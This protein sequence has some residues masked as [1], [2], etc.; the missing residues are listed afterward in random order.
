MQP[1]ILIVEDNKKLG[2]LFKEAL[3]E[4]FSTRIAG[5]LKQAAHQLHGC[6]GIVLDLQLPDGDGLELI[7]QAKR[8][9]P[10]CVIIVVTAYGT[11]QR[12]VEA[13]R[14]GATDF[15]E[16]P[17]D[18]EELCSRFLDLLVPQEPT[19]LVA[20]SPCMLQVISLAQRVAPTPFPVLIS[21]PTGA[22]KEVIARYIHSR[23]ERDKFISVNCA[24]VPGELADSLLFGHLKGSFTGAT[25][26]RQG[27]VAAADN[28]TLFLDEIGE[29]PL[30]LQPKLLRFLDSGEYLPIGSSKVQKSGARI[31]AATNRDLKEEMEKGKF[32]EDLYFRLA[33]FPLQI[34]PLRR[35]KADIPPLVRFHLSRLKETLKSPVEISEQAMELLQEYHFPGNVRELF[36][37]L[38][39]AA[40]LSG[41]VIERDSLEPLLEQ[42][43]DEGQRAGDLWSES[44]AEA[45]KR[46]K[47]MIL[48]ALAAAGGN[49]AAAAR[50]L[51]VSYKTLFN[52]MKKYGISQSSLNAA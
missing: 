50:A 51:K 9:N 7:S 32:R 14:M 26:A 42:V 38:D 8:E 40:V 39:R 13:L 37:L 29:M 48:A 17:V 3:E 24:A 31:I 2:E 21:G 45:E 6:Q 12:A 16:K 43:P 36:N 15:L 35:R 23:S 46:E 22:G 10:G 28:G 52:K 1:S 11:V 41:G 18:L 20:E 19:E 47:E 4:H 25:E 33:T 5:T 30:S 34:P 49:K 44:K 27:L